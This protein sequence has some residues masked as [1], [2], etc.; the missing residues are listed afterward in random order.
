MSKKTFGCL[1]GFAVNPRLEPA[2]RT[3]FFRRLYGWRDQSQY[4]K[5]EYKREGLL[6]HIPHIRLTRGVFIVAQE[7]KNKITKFLRGK[8]KIVTR[9]VVLTLEDKKKLYSK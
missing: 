3:K 2:H 8:T 9:Q 1:I 7:S 4:G 6:T 5:Y